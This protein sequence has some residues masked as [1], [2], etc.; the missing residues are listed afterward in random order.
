MP[1]RSQTAAR[2]GLALLSSNQP[3]HRY[4]NS[5]VACRRA[6]GHARPAVRGARRERRG[7]RSRAASSACCPKAFVRSTAVW[8]RPESEQRRS[9]A[10]VRRR[11]HGRP[12]DRRVAAVGRASAAL[13][14][15]ARR[16]SSEPAAA[17]FDS[18]S[19]R[20]RQLHVAQFGP[21]S[22]NLRGRPPQVNLARRLAVT[23][24][25]SDPLALLPLLCAAA[26]SVSQPVQA[27]LPCEGGVNV[28]PA[29][30]SCCSTRRHLPTRTFGSDRADQGY[31]QTL[32]RR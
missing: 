22:K 17:P 3:G 7:E 32:R 30:P 27:L 10:R 23:V 5:F 28:V 13:L 9:L 14:E 4:R 12:P 18:A 25:P 6:G 11:D 1:S 29:R 24:D 26:S 19:R 20:S 16:G 21:P 2:P 15:E 8:S 31:A